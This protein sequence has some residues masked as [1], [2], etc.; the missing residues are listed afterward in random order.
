MNS[1]WEN[2]FHQKFLECGFPCEHVLIGTR[3]SPYRDTQDSKVLSPLVS[4]FLRSLMK[5]LTA[6]AS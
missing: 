2:V 4:H 6:L 3:L 5:T 1:R